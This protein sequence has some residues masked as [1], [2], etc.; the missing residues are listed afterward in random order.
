MVT[1]FDWGNGYCQS[2]ANA[3]PATPTANVQINSRP[4]IKPKH[5]FCIDLDEEEEKQDKNSMRFLQ[6]SSLYST[7]LHRVWFIEQCTFNRII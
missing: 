5:Y 6:I 1:Y 7:Y 2:Q 3:K 4:S